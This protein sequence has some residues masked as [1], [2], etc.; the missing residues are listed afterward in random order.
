MN[1]TESTVIENITTQRRFLADTFRLGSGTVLAQGVMILSVPV[2]SRIYAP[3]S[4]GIAALFG[5]LII[6]LSTIAGLRYELAILLPEDDSDGFDLLLLQIGLVF[7]ISS[8]LGVLFWLAKSPIS[9]WLNSP[10]LE[11]YIWFVGPGAIVLS[12]LNGLSYW[13][14]RRKRFTFL[15]VARFVSSIGTAITQLLA[16]FLSAATAGGLIGG[17]VFGKALED[18]VQGWRVMSDSRRIGMRGSGFRKLYTLAKR[19]KKFPIFTTWSALVNTLSWQIT[20][21]FLAIFFAPTIVG[22]YTV[23]ERV[24]RTPMNMLGRSISQVF[25]QRGAAAYRQGNLSTVFLNTTQILSRIGL[26]PTLVLT[27]A[28]REIFIVV[29]GAQWAEAGVYVQI[30]GVWAFVW[31]L[32]SPTSII[33]S[34]AEQ[35]EKALFFNTINLLTRIAS[36]L[37]GGLLGQPR[38][39]LML[40]S[41]SG[42]ITYGWLLILVGQIAGVPWRRTLK[43]IISADWY[44]AIGV[45]LVLLALKILSL[46]N[47]S[48]VIIAVLMLALYFGYIVNRYKYFFSK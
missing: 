7:V 6:I 8:I 27:I 38:L 21:F 20:P 41:L 39:A 13:N 45:V 42:V 33:M 15:A 36:L 18:G 29:L 22:F 2:L 46:S 17:N 23:G 10:E 31:F 32:S 19:Y 28:G 4:F 14:T 16:G 40:F 48:I 37:V 3:E 43:E 30:L 26:L 24:I 5:S 12:L 1:K 9:Q 44:W 11:K 25:F 34:I 47:I 35:Q